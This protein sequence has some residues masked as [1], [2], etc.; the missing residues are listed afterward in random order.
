MK[1]ILFPILALV[2]SLGLT[3]PTAT[4]AKADCTVGISLNISADPTEVCSCDPVGLRIDLNFDGTC[5]FV[6][7]EPAW[8]DLAPLGLT[9]APD[10]FSSEYDWSSNLDGDTILEFGETWTWTLTTDVCETTT[11]AA[12][13]TAIVKDCTWP[14]N[15][16]G[17]VTVTVV[18]CDGGEG[19]TPGYWKA[20]NHRDDWIPTGYS[21][22]D[23]FSTVFGVTQV[24]DKTLL[25]A[26]N[27]GGGGVRKLLRH[28]TAALLNAAHP[29][30]D[31][32][33]T[34]GEVIGWVQ[35]AYA[36]DKFGD[37]A[38]MFAGFNQLGGSP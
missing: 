32:P 19:L 12:T 36:E 21:T 26:L 7:L 20:K 4:P 35:Y 15:A 37:V 24:P 11:F 30:V 9:L 1:K 22:G 34:V 18:P 16:S 10:P 3:L 17:S 27:T 8:V 38:D 13:A 6:P 29:G 23:S 31:Y 2:L 33:L 14:Y 5:D 25:Q 28:G